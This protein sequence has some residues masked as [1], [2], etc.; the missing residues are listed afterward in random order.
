MINPS[1][2]FIALPNKLFKVIAA[3]WLVSFTDD[4]KPTCGEDSCLVFQRCD[5]IT[6]LQDFGIKLGSL[7][8]TAE[9]E[10]I[11]HR[12]SIKE[13]HKSAPM[14][15]KIPVGSYLIPGPLLGFEEE[16]CYLSITGSVPDDIHS[17]VLGQPFLENYFTVLDQEN[18]KIGLG[19]HLGS[20]AEISEKMF[21]SMKFSIWM[22]A[23]TIIIM[24]GIF[25][26][27]CFKCV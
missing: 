12:G 2:P 24:L 22:L 20:D 3:E 25:I 27:M 26:Y 10:D 17:A 19:A 15:F 16:L 8:E 6:Q 18:M 23:A 5:S 11:I 7:N 9:S 14:Y 1:S 13:V 21:N 4:K